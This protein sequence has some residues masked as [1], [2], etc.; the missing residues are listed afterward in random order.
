MHVCI[1]IE[2]VCSCLK[3]PISCGGSL[4]KQIKH[5]VYTYASVCNQDFTIES[6]Y[7]AC[8]LHF[9][10]SFCVGFILHISPPSLPDSKM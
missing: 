8:P 1:A 5:C 6:R 10:L 9:S 2:E 3:S 7:Y 4:A